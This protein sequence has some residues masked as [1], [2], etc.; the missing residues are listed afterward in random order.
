M[1]QIIVIIKC[2]TKQHGWSRIHNCHSLGLGSTSLLISFNIMV[3]KCTSA[4]CTDILQYHDAEVY[5]DLHDRCF[6]YYCQWSKYDAD[7]F[8]GDVTKQCWWLPSDPCNKFHFYFCPLSK[9]IIIHLGRTK[10]FSN[11]HVKHFKGFP[12]LLTNCSDFT[13]IR[14][15]WLCVNHKKSFCSFQWHWLNASSSSALPTGM[16]DHALPQPTVPNSIYQFMS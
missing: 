9:H 1:Y 3:Q 11:S 15:N 13:V 12:W 6:H 8:S 7:F 2:L 16:G 4:S 10:Q 5:T 14:W